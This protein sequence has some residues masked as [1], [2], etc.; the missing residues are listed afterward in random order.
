M[1]AY[2]LRVICMCVN[3]CERERERERDVWDF[4]LHFQVYRSHLRSTYCRCLL[5][6]M[7]QESHWRSRRAE[8]RREPG[9]L[10]TPSSA[11]MAKWKVTFCHP[12]VYMAPQCG[13]RKQATSTALDNER[14]LLSECV[15]NGI[16]CFKHD[17]FFLIN[18]SV[19]SVLSL[20]VDTRHMGVCPV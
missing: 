15:W 19:R 9:K 7:T 17:L 10:I 16:S 13:I 6:R 12:N 18:H 8:Q 20:K 5:S 11:K 2:V 14:A 4:L 1:C 3:V